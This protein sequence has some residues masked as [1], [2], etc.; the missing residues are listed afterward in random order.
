MSCVCVGFVG[1]LRDVKW[2]SVGCGWCSVSRCPLPKRQHST[3]S[4]LHVMVCTNPSCC[5][6]RGWMWACGVACGVV[7]AGKKREDANTVK[8]KQKGLFP[9]PLFP[10]SLFSTSFS[11]TP[12]SLPSTLPPSLPSYPNTHLFFMLHTW[13]HSWW[14]KNTNDTTSDSFHHLFFL[15]KLSFSLLFILWM[16]QRWCNLNQILSNHQITFI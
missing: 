10:F 9:K 12:F 4:C 8:Q 11:S 13:V 1:V 15:S 2:W 7:G 5:V 16:I 14:T 6:V 3:Q